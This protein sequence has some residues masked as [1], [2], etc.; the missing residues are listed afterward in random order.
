MIRSPRLRAA[1]L[2]AHLGLDS[3]PVSDG[4]VYL[5]SDQ[6]LVRTHSLPPELPG[7]LVRNWPRSVIWLRKE[8]SEPRRRWTLWHEVGHFL[9]H[10]GVYY[11]M[12]SGFGERR[13]EREADEFAVEMLM[14]KAWL[15]RDLATLTTNPRQLAVR[16]GVS[17]QAMQ[18][19]LG[20]LGV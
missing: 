16:Y 17:V 14:P 11:C 9:L 5:V 18:I 20:E 8:D 10:Q 7:M 1:A 3:P 2:R 15:L 6:I 13:T 4:L 19:R 12:A